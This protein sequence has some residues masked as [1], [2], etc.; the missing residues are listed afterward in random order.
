MAKATNPNV[1]K[2]KKLFDEKA[3]MK[4][5]DKNIL[6]KKVVHK[7]VKCGIELHSNVDNKMD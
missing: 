4:R 6:K 7:M 3:K 2:L 5:K 1:A